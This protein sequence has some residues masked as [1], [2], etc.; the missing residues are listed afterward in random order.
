[1]KKYNKS[2]DLRIIFLRLASKWLTILIV[3]LAFA[4]IVGGFNH[5]KTQKNYKEQ[6]AIYKVVKN[7]YENDLAIFNNK[8]N[9]YENKISELSN[10]KNKLLNRINYNSKA[11]GQLVFSV[12]NPK[13][14]NEDELAL[15]FTIIN[16]TI[17]NST[18][19]EKLSIISIDTDI[20][21][22][23]ISNTMNNN[24]VLLTASIVAVDDETLNELV[25]SI[26]DLVFDSFSAFEVNLFEK[27]IKLIDKEELIILK[28]D[29]N[30]INSKIKDVSKIL[31][32]LKKNSVVEPSEPID[33]P[34]AKSSIIIGFLG[35]LLGL[36]LI[37]IYFILK[38]VLKPY[39]N[40][41]NFTSDYLSLQT[42]A[43]IDSE[44]YKKNFLTKLFMR[45][46]TYSNDDAYGIISVYVKEKQN[47]SI[48]SF[49]DTTEEN[50]FKD[51]V[52]VDVLNCNS[53][54]SSLFDEIAKKNNFIILIDVE[55]SKTAQV[56]EVYNFIKNIGLDIF[57]T[58]IY[59]C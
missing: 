52:N 8:V 24:D 54:L 46:S 5:Y 16:N 9:E 36:W 48:L 49:L 33:K 30:I 4:V 2:I 51:N 35:F 44:H 6:I 40:N 57:G 56:V 10:E 47:L 11:R 15:F 43:I 37:G 39:I 22:I 23:N 50:K 29:L 3:A 28:N 41:I 14:N 19:A 13:I 18:I 32:N 58:V 17:N 42:L 59:T 20:F 38:I 31:E 21:S 55:K 1:M 53:C 25:S 12:K 34:L 7:S 27:Q 45:K 26:H